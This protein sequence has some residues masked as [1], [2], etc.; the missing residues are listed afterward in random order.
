MRQK[1]FTCIV[2]H[3]FHFKLRCSPIFTFPRCYSSEEQ[4][5]SFLRFAFHLQN[6]QKQLSLQEIV[7]FDRMV[8]AADCRGVEVVGRTFDRKVQGSSPDRN[9]IGCHQERHPDIKWLIAPSKSPA[10][11]A[12]STYPQHWENGYKTKK[13]SV[14]RLTKQTLHRNSCL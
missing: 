6:C 2:L 14:Q 9:I 8:W 12:P 11:Q 5:E 13:K 10:M 1:S 7:R 4:K 3:P